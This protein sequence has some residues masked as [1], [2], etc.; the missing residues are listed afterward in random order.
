MMQ[1]VVVDDILFDIV[2]LYQLVCDEKGKK[3]FK[4]MGNVIDLLEIVDEYGV[5]VLCF[6]NVLMV[7]IGGVLKLLVD[8]IKGYCNFGIKLWNVC[9]FV[10]MN[11]VQYGQVGILIVIVI[12]NKWIIGEVVW[13]CEEFDLV[14]VEYCFNDVVG[15]IYVF[16]WGKVCDWYV[17]FVKLL[18]M[19]GDD[20]IKDEI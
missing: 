10:E 12:V 2:Y 13:V 14:F 3:M 20:V 17:E 18:L 15:V 9:C 19:D 16:V 6:V 5:D 4:I 11:G 1:F 7:F 8:W